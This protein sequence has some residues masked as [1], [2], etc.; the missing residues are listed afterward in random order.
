MMQIATLGYILLIISTIISGLASL[1]KAIVIANIW[2]EGI[3]EDV[4]ISDYVLLVLG[5]YTT[6]ICWWGAWATMPYTIWGMN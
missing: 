4:R 3:G 1:F 6:A 5:S 2:A